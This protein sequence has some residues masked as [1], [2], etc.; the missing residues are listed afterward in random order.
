MSRG[1]RPT[2]PDDGR[3]LALARGGDGR[4]F[5]ELWRRYERRFS[6]LVRRM[7]CC[8]EDANDILQDGRLRAYQRVG[9]CDGNFPSWVRAVII[10]CAKDYFRRAQRHPHSSF[11]ELEDEEELDTEKQSWLIDERGEPP[12]RSALRRELVGDV[13]RAVGHL[14]RAHP[15]QADAICLRYFSDCSYAEMSKLLPGQPP[16]VTC[17]S[18]CHRGQKWLRHELLRKHTEQELLVSLSPTL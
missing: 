5:E 6:G 2:G 15:L 14:R 1:Q 9:M 4:A 8:A 13:R 11:T 12:L 3:L 7:D 17:R 16:E 10:N 18:L